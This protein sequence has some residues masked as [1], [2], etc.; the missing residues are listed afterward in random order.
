MEAWKKNI[1]ELWVKR[2]ADSDCLKKLVE[3]TLS[4]LLQLIERGVA[5]IKF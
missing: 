5:F 3:G 2:M 1:T 4:G